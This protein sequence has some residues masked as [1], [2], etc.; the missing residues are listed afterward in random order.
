MKNTT[1]TKCVSQATKALSSLDVKDAAVITAL[2]PL[3]F[4]ITDAVKEIASEAMEN[5]C[6]FSFKCP[7]A[8]VNLEPADA[9]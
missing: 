7:F 5:G 1:I 9:S 3:A 8:E 2:I 6:K 4:Y